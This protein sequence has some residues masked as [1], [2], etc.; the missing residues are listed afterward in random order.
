MDGWDGLD[1]WLS[2]TAVTPRASLQ[3]DA[4]KLQFDGQSCKKRF[5]LH[6]HKKI[7][8]NTRKLWRIR[9]RHKTREFPINHKQKQGKVSKTF[10]GICP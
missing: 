1:G 9:L 3:S 5:K 2:Y 6:K 10:Y 4:N 7:A 8:S